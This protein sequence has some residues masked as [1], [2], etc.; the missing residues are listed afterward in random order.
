MHANPGATE[1]SYPPRAGVTK[2]CEPPNMGARNPT[3]TLWKS[4]MCSSA[5][6]A[7]APAAPQFN[8]FLFVCLFACLK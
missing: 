6:L 2:D 4:S 7:L 5:D 1:A 3:L 8:W